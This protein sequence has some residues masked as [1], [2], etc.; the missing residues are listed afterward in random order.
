MLVAGL[1]VYCIGLVILFLSNGSKAEKIRWTFFSLCV[2]VLLVL[3]AMGIIA[4]F[5][6]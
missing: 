3:G 1:P 5:K 4:Y 2:G 6:L